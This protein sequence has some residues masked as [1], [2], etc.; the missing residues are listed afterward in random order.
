MGESRNF[1]R[2]VLKF[3]WSKLFIWSVFLLLTYVLRHFFFII[4]MTF[5]I[6][7]LMGNLIGF[8]SESILHRRSIAVK[9]ILTIICFLTL[10]ISGYGMA[11]F[12]I[13]RFVQ[14]GQSLIKKMSSIE[15]SPRKTLDGLLRIT[16]GHWL[17]EQQYGSAGDTEFDQAFTEYQ[18]KPLYLQA[19][20]QFEALSSK[21]DLQVE[22]DYIK[23]QAKTAASTNGSALTVFKRIKDAQTDAYI[24][25]VKDYYAREIAGTSRSPYSWNQY[26]ALYPTVV[27]NDR[28]AFSRLYETEYLAK[29]TSSE[30]EDLMQS[31]FAYFQTN[32]LVT[33]W[34]EGPMAEK[35]SNEF[36]KK[37]LGLF[38]AFGN[39]LAGM[40][41][42]LLTLPIQLTLSLMLSFF[43]TFDIDRL[44]EGASR[45]KKSRVGH[46]YEEIIPGLQTFAS[47][48]GRAFQAQGCIAIVNAILTWI[49]I[50]ILG[51]ENGLF[52]SVIVFLCSFIPVLGV[53]LSGAPI[54]AMAIIQDGGGFMLALWAILGIL[55]IHFIETSLLN[56]KIV[57]TFLHLHPVLVLVILALGEHFFG[58]WGLLLGLPVAVY[59]I[60]IVILDEGLPWEKK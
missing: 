52:L 2:S 56:P 44:R 21:I 16:V 32:A 3:S 59:I 9:K 4:F 38:G 33:T 36:D 51:I 28:E 60:R 37:V 53:V 41:P 43:I 10:L 26:Q 57:G 1:F 30:K 50:K 58:A 19:F 29:L 40:I 48:I 39:Y 15:D 25:L 35:L 11:K 12:F 22:R 45:L 34:K 13:P 20:D 18:K 54:A 46:I 6:A 14:Q 27:Q 7:Y 5:L 42:A 49:V 8:I 55:V 17:F 31:N 47:L 24:S 23:Q